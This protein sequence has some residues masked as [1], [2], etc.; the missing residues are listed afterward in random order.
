M[1]LKLSSRSLTGLKVKAG[2]KCGERKEMGTASTDVRLTYL[3]SWLTDSF[4]YR[5]LVTDSTF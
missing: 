4:H 3:E 2:I 5:L 1:D